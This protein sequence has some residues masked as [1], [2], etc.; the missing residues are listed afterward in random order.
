MK[1]IA[2]EHPRVGLTVQFI[3]LGNCTALDTVVL[4]LSSC[5]DNNC[6]YITTR[7]GDLMN[8]IANDHPREGF[9][10][11]FIIWGHYNPL[12]TKGLVTFGPLIMY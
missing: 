9:S 5:N 3:I 11:Q 2:N 6:S 1:Y 10:I 4:V 12:V 7:I 8:Y